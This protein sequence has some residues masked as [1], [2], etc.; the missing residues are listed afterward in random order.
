V[1]SKGRIHVATDEP[2]RP[3]A[4][5]VEDDDAMGRAFARVLK[6][7]G[8]AVS[9]SG[10]GAHAFQRVRDGERFDLV[11]SDV[12]MPVMNGIA[13]REAALP[14]WPELAGALVFVSGAIDLDFSTLGA[15][16]FTKPVGVEFYAH[17]RGMR[18]RP[19]RC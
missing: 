5:V 12:C 13:F 15:P 17:V 8:F 6:R 4:L 10:T 7:I 14:L 19:E 9:S 16:C 2:P 3:H 18:R 1:S 11:V